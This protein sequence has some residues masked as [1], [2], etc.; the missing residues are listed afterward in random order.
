MPL[1]STL[2][3]E[4]QTRLA[5]HASTNDGAR[6]LITFFVGQVVGQLDRVKP[7]KQVVL[8]MVEE[9]I[10]TVERMSGTLLGD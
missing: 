8:E 1:H 2:I 7:A 6:E 5:R 10:D 4:A 3:D 9:H